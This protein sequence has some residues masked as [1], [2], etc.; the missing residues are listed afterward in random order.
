MDLDGT[1]WDH[2][3]ISTLKPP[4]KKTSRYTFIDSNNVEV[5]VYE[6]AVKILEY[7][8]ERKIIT[9]TL[10]WNNP[11]IALE[12]L[13]TIELDRLFHYHAIENHPDKAK[14]T[15]KIANL[16]KRSYGCSEVYPIY[17]DDRELHLNDMINALPNLLYIKAWKTCT[18]FND[19]IALIENYLKSTSY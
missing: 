2:Y 11:E 17:I 3:D 4:F 8:L 12:A 7:S 1:L 18:N 6:L 19:C 9:S 14:M 13:K 16:V 5:H 15:L 10:S